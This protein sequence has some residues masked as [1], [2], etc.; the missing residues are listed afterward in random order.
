MF[1]RRVDVGGHRGDCGPPVQDGAIVPVTFHL[2]LLSAWSA[3]THFSMESVL[4]VVTLT[5]KSYLLAPTGSPLVEN[6][7]P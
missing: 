3:V 6:R 7:P 1:L 5:E 2:Y 4:D